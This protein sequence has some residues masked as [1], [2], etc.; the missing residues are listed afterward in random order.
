MV[1][2]RFNPYTEIRTDFN[3]QGGA[4]QALMLEHFA[5]VE[6][7][8]SRIIA[9]MLKVHVES[10]DF[11]KELEEMVIS[12]ARRRADDMIKSMTWDIFYDEEFKEQMQGAI[13]KMMKKS[14]N[15]IFE[16]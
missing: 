5:G 2:T 14:L 15:K 8:M 12:E 9:D 6:E 3:M 7:Q 1:K 16:Y 4:I 13:Q 10:I 11:K